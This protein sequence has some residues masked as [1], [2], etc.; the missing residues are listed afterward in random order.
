[1][2]KSQIK[3]RVLPHFPA[4]A[5]MLRVDGVSLNTAT[6]A[7]YLTFL[8]TSVSDLVAYF[9]SR[10]ARSTGEIH[11]DENSNE[12]AHTGNAPGPSAQATQVPAT[13]A[14]NQGRTG[15]QSQMTPAGSQGSF[16]SWNFPDY[17]TP[18]ASDPPVPPVSGVG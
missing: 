3:V 6:T 16:R 5:S 7:A 18:I 12:N 10:D 8:A 13:P 9:T 1:M 15:S 17:S 2:D 11:L 14:N 4:E